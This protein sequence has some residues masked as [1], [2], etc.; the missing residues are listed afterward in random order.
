MRPWP[1]PG[2][3]AKPDG[4]QRLATGPNDHEGLGRERFWDQTPDERRAALS[5]MV[6][7]DGIDFA[8]KTNM[9]YFDAAGGDRTFAR[10]WLNELERVRFYG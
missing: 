3:P 6:A 1:R 7:D 10:G 9:A 8:A 2:G 4:P 5:A